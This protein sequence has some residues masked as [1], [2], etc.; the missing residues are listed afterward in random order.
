MRLRLLLLA[1]T[2]SGGVGVDV[3]TGGLLRVRWLE[4]APVFSI[5]DLVETDVRRDEALPFP[6]DMVVGSAPVRVGSLRGRRAEHLLRPLVHPAS[7]PLLGAPTA[8]V[9]YW[10]IRADAPSVAIVAPAAGPVLERDGTR[11]LRCRFRWRR[12][13]HDLPFEDPALGERLAHPTADRL[14]GGTLA[15]ALGWK[16]DRLVVSLDAPVEGRCDKVVTGLLP[17]P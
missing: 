2:P 1:S 14:A 17:R 16:P 6:N 9:T 10:T 5:Y 3:A 8:T 12:L 11:G 13:D 7:Q 15:R 4:R